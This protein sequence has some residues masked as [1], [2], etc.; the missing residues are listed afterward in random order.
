MAAR[1][2]SLLSRTAVS[3]RPTSVTFSNPLDAEA[4]DESLVTISPELSNGKLFV[5]DKTLRIEGQARGR[6]TYHITLRAG[7]QDQYGQTLGEDQTVT[8]EDVYEPYL[9]QLG[10]LARTPRGRIATLAAYR[11]LGV[12]P[13]QAAGG[14]PD[15]G[16]LP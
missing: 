5:V 3:G 12:A 7:I 4:F 11:H 14:P 16:A 13:P 9:L 2:R 6:T 10:F 15:I 1:T 8:I